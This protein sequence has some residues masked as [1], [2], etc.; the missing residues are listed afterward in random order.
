MKAHVMKSKIYLIPA[1]LV[2]VFLCAS[3]GSSKEIANEET[4]EETANCNPLLEWEVGKMLTDGHIELQA[5]DV[6][7]ENA[8]LVF[9]VEYSGCGNERVDLYWN[10]IMTNSLP[11]QIS[12][13]PII[14]EP[15]LCDM[16]VQ[17]ELSYDYSKI[18]K[19]HEEVLVKFKG[20]GE[21]ISLKAN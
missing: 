18:L 7:I 10:G 20:M 8:C 15:G 3:C 9:N 1:T 13:Q 12:L 16:M 5:Q 19:N 14:L 21:M 11:P 17:K 2:A 6:R 4:V